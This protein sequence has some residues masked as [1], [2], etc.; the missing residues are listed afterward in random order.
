[1]DAETIRAFALAAGLDKALA[2]FPD[3]VAAAAAA[4][5]ANLDAINVTTDAAVEPWP[6]MRAGSSA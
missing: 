4:A 2:E 1:M 6:P 3:D 5:A